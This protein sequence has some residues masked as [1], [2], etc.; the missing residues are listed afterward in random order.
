MYH[1]TI[2]EL[3]ESDETTPI[4]TPYRRITANTQALNNLAQFTGTENY[5]RHLGI[6]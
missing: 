5:H 6:Q 3:S 1:V 2:L 4:L